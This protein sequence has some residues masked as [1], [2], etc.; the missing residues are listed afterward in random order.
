MALYK[1]TGRT[2][3]VPCIDLDGLKKSLNQFE[4]FYV[5]IKENSVC[6]LDIS[7]NGDF[8]RCYLDSAHNE[9]EFNV[10]HHIMPFIDPNSV[11]VILHCGH[12]KHADING[13]AEAYYQDNH[14]SI[15][16]DD[17]YDKALE[18]FGIEPTKAIE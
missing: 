5:V 10:T 12:T 11:L 13:Y 6:I 3:Y 15:S 9:I 4:D 1:G 7:E 8:S 18:A 17:I 14:I 2:N 16:L